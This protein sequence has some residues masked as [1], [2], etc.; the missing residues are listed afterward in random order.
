MRH[1]L[2]T[3]GIAAAASLLAFASPATACGEDTDCAVEGGTYRIHLPEGGTPD[4]AIFFA[5]GYR[6]TAGGTMRNER[7]VGLADDLDVALVALQSAEEDWTLPNSPN[8][9]RVPQRDEVAYVLRVKDDVV[10]RFGIDPDRMLFAGFS[11]GGMLTWTVACSAGDVF[12]AFVPLSGTFWKT[13]P[14]RCDTDAAITHYHGTS[15]TVV[16]IE[17]RAI[18]PTR[19]GDMNDVIAMYRADRGLS[20]PVRVEATGL[21]CTR[22]PGPPELGTYLEYCTHPGG[23]RFS[24]DYIRRIWERDLP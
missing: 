8:A 1:A 15:D 7:L 3:L 17:G 9:G 13:P 10:T 6:G 19:Q 18:G 22:W 23:H 11:A 2:R 24:V 20:A 12:F 5:H 4:G 21:E 14:D 16:P